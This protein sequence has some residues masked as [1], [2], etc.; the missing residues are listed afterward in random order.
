MNRHDWLIRLCAVLISSFIWNNAAI[1]NTSADA[2][3]GG[4][5]AGADALEGGG[6][7]S[8]DALEEASMLPSKVRWTITLY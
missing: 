5:G 2:L 6:T 8:A 4:N 3:E 7:M 1:A